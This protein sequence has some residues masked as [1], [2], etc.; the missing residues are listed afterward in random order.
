MFKCICESL[1]MCVRVCVR[2]DSS[3]HTN[4]RNIQSVIH[5][6]LVGKDLMF[7]W[8]KQQWYVRKYARACVYKCMLLYMKVCVCE[9]VNICT[10]RV[11]DGIVCKKH[12]YTYLYVVMMYACVFV[13]VCILICLFKLSG[14]M[15]PFF[16]V[17]LIALPS[18][19]NTTYTQRTTT[20]TLPLLAGCFLTNLNLLFVLLIKFP[21]ITHPH[22][23]TTFTY[24]QARCLWD[25]WLYL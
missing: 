6:L 22:S 16:I 21:P 7:T 24:T 25:D 10:I 20:I 19:F 1:Y 8:L 9:Y 4:S 12:T 2:K 3:I 23:L 17:V 11:M 5:L 13:Y 14:S 15:C 18:C